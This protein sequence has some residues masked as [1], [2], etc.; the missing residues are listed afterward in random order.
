R[1]GREQM[2]RGLIFWGIAAIVVGCSDSKEQK[3]TS[4]V[5][6]PSVVR[7]GD[8]P[9][10]TVDEG[11]GEPVAANAEEY[12]EAADLVRQYY[13]AISRGSYRRAFDLWEKGTREFEEFSEE[14]K[15]I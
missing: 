2:I 6:H 9:Q 7:E 1:T 8:E 14:A 5:D 12:Q 3:V 10:G 15:S 4:R 13:T 11:E